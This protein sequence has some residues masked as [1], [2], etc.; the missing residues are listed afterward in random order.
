MAVVAPLPLLLLLGNDHILVDLTLVDQ[1]TVLLQSINQ[2]KFKLR[3]RKVER[4]D[5]LLLPSPSSSSC[6]MITSW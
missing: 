1:H 4:S 2:L 6:D 5:M 3:I